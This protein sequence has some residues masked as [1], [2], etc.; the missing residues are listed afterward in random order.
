MEEHHAAEEEETSAHGTAQTQE[1]KQKFRED[2]IDAN[3][4]TSANDQKGSTE[5]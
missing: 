4:E 1:Q 5:A 3:Q 2:S